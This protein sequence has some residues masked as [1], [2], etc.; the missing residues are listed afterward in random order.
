MINIHDRSGEIPNIFPP[1]VER[2]L[3]VSCKRGRQDALAEQIRGELQA[4][5]DRLASI[6]SKRKEINRLIDEA[7]NKG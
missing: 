2:I 3:V 1:Q 7:F 4:L 6:E 5:D